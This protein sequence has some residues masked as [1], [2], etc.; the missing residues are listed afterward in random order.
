MIIEQTSHNGASCLDYLTSLVASPRCSILFNQIH[1]D[2]FFSLFS[3][4]LLTGIASCFIWSLYSPVRHFERCL[5][6]IKCC[7]CENDCWFCFLLPAG[8]LTWRKAWLRAAC[9]PANHQ[10]HYISVVFKYLQV[11]AGSILI[12]Y[13]ILLKLIV[14]VIHTYFSYKKA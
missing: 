2:H 13:K 5:W 4:D 8:A 14:I 12:F 9:Y 6:M 3:F 7:T 10:S 1:K 11:M